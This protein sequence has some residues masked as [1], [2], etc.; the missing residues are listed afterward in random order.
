M[1]CISLSHT[2]DSSNGAPCASEME[3]LNLDN[4]NRPATQDGQSQAGPSSQVWV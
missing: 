1:E 4:R 3:L 2:V